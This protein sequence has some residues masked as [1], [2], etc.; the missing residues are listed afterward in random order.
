MKSSSRLFAAAL[1][2]VI[3]AH[4]VVPLEAQEGRGPISSPVVESATRAELQALLLDLETAA[5]GGGPGTAGVVQQAERIRARLRDGDFRTGDAILLHVEGEDALSDTLVVSPGRVLRVSGI[6]AIPLTGVLRSELESHLTAT[7][8]RYLKDPVI[9]T[10]LLIRLAVSGEVQAPG[11]YVMPRDALLS[12][13][14]MTAGGPTREA[15]VEEVSI[16]RG[17]E[18]LWDA[19]DVRTG[20]AEGRTLAHFDLR[21]GDRL[22]VPPHSS[23]TGLELLRILLL[24]IPTAIVA[25]TQF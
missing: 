1:A 17:D 16:E 11:F 19:D 6:G 15:A 20:I 10:S 8:A 18:R 22:V 23:M 14:L 5:V 2:A 12:E 13:A 9:R 7:L 21:S 24:A 4:G 25:F 3:L